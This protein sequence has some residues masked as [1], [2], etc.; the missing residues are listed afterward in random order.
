M[1]TLS[2]VMDPKMR[3]AAGKDPG[4]LIRMYGFMRRLAEMAEKQGLPDQTPYKEKLEV[5]RINLLANAMLDYHYLSIMVTPEE[6][7]KHYEDNKANFREAKLK[8]IFLP[9]LDATEEA[10][11]KLRAEEIVSRLHKGEDFAKLVKEF[12]KHAESVEKGGDFGPIKYF[13]NLPANIKAAIFALQNGQVSDPVRHT[14]GYYIFRMEELTVP[15]YDKLK[16]EIFL[17][18]KDQRKNDWLNGVRRSVNV[19]MVEPA[20][21]A[22]PAKP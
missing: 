16:D 5:S 19:K 6:Q 14:N 17:A 15:P 3:E 20:G 4:E 10:Q 2:V 9:F 1:N 21:Q 11:A 7:K 12:S 22:A 18:I 13:E 8:M